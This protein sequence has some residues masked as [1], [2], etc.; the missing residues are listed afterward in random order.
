MKKY[1]VSVDITMC[2]MVDVEANSE[3]EALDKVDQMISNNP[4]D[5]T[6]GFSHYVT[7]DVVNAEEE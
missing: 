4:Y 7:H 5:Y 2:K 3:Q 1:S 6:T